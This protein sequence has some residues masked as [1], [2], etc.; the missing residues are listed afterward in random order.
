MPPDSLPAFTDSLQRLRLL[1]PSQLNE[2]VAQLSARFAEP[3][4]LAGELVKRGWLT[5]FQ[6]N[7]LARGRGEE[8]V[9]GQYLLLDRLGEGGMGT[10]YKARH[11][12]LDRLVTLK[13]IRKEQ[14][15]QGETVRRF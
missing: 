2:L 12:R 11:L 5:P 10:V 13:V 1:R 9:L 4:A 14:F 7:Q 3:R 8:L 15:H 6:V